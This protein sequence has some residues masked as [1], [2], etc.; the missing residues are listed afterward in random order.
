MIEFYPQIKHAHIGIALLSG[1]IFAIRGAFV[2][3]G[4]KWPR[5]AA[6]RWTS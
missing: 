1:I 3:G 2:M 5:H 6:V 4:A